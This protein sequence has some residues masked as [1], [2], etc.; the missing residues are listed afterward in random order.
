MACG[1]ASVLRCFTI[2]VMAATLLIGV[3]DM[4]KEGETYYSIAEKCDD[5]SILFS[6]P[7]VHDSEDIV[8]GV[9]LRINPKW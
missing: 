7:N 5:Q 4:V 9:I 2:V 6:N 1:G 8:P 3:N